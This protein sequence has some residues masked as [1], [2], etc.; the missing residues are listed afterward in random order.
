MK[1][2]RFLKCEVCVCVCVFTLL[3]LTKNAEGFKK[4]EIGE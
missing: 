3:N 4:Y 2:G 1:A